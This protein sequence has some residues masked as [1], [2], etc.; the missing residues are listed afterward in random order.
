MPSRLACP[1][2]VYPDCGAKPLARCHQKPPL[3]V[4]KRAAKHEQVDVVAPAWIAA[5]GPAAAA[6]AVIKPAGGCL[7]MVGTFVVGGSLPLAM[8]PPLALCRSQLHRAA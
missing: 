3:M 5:G 4:T 8:L 7:W 2:T 1:T 6:A